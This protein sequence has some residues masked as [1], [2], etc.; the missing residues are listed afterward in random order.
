MSAWL[1][2]LYTGRILLTSEICTALS[3]I[4]GAHGPARLH[5]MIRRYNGDLSAVVPSDVPL[6][7]RLHLAAPAADALLL[8]E[9]RKE[10]PFFVCLLRCRSSY[11]NALFSDRWSHDAAIE[12]N[13]CAGAVHVFLRWCVGAA[14]AELGLD[15]DNAAD[16]LQLANALNT[17]PL[18]RDAERF[19]SQ[20]IFEAIDEVDAEMV[21]ALLDLATLLER[22][23]FANMLRDVLARIAGRRK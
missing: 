23:S 19:L 12:L 8:S 10:F 14:G 2:Y 22:T 11:F 13:Y 3:P 5:A 21:Q 20:R 4:V 9:D 15:D 1:S 17:V 18:L 7:S 6:F 16:V